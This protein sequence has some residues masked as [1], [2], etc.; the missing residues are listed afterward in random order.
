M[1][2]SPPPGAPPVRG[3]QGHGEK[4]SEADVKNSGLGNLD[5]GW[6]NSRA[7]AGDVGDGM[8][9][10]VLERVREILE[11]M[12]GEGKEKEDESMAEG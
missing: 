9:R 3:A 6:L 5:I 7:G 1:S 10:E 4:D 8:Q 12:V 11:D 2:G